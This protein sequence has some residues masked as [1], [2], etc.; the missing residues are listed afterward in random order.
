MKSFLAVCDRSHK[1]LIS[2]ILITGIGCGAT[3][4]VVPPIDNSPGNSNILVQSWSARNKLIAKEITTTSLE[5]SMHSLDWNEDGYP[6]LVL[7]EQGSDQLTLQLNDG[8]GDFF[9]ISIALPESINTIESLRDFNQDGTIDLLT[10]NQD[11]MLGIYY[12][13]GANIFSLPKKNL[14]HAADIVSIVDINKDKR[15][16]IILTT[17][18]GINILKNLPSGNFDSTFVYAEESRD[19][20]IGFG[21]S[22]KLSLE[23]GDLDGDGDSDLII[24]SPI[25]G[26]RHWYK[27]EGDFS[28]SAIVL[29]S[30]SRANFATIRDFDNDGDID[31]LIN[32]LDPSA[33]IL[34]NDGKGNFTNLKLDYKR[35]MG[36]TYNRLFPRYVYS[37]DI[38]ADGDFDLIEMSSHTQGKARVDG[39]NIFENLG[40]VS[41]VLHSIAIPTNMSYVNFTDINADGAMDIVGLNAENDKKTINWLDPSDSRLIADNVNLRLVDATDYTNTNNAEY[42]IYGK[43]ATLFSVNSQTGDLQFK[44]APKLSS[45]NDRNRNNIYELFLRRTADKKS[46]NKKFSISI[47]QDDE[48]DDNDGVSDIHDQFPLDPRESTDSDL[49][50]IGNNEDTDDDNDGALDIIDNAPTDPTSTRPPVWIR[51]P[52][53]YFVVIEGSSTE[54]NLTASDIDNNP[55]EF[56]VVSATP[57]SETN[58][59]G[60]QLYVKAP[61]LA[62]LDANKERPSQIEVIVAAGDGFSN[63]NHVLVVNLLADDG[64]ADDDGVEDKND[65]FPTD[66]SESTD[67]DG[68]GVGDNAD[69]DDDGDGVADYS[70]R[71]P[72][73]KSSFSPPFWESSFEFS[74]LFQHTGDSISDFLVTDIDNDGKDDIVVLSQGKENQLYYYHQTPESEFG[75]SLI[76]GNL[77]HYGRLYTADL[78]NDSKQE[79][80]LGSQAEILVFQNSDGDNFTQVSL[81]DVEAGDRL[82]FGDINSDGKTDIV[83]KRGDKGPIYLLENNGDL[84][85]TQ[86]LIHQAYDQILD[87]ALTDFDGNGT[88][89][90]FG[91]SWIDKPNIVF[92]NDGT[93]NLTQINHRISADFRSTQL[94]DINRDGKMDL[95]DYSGRDPQWFEQLDNGNFTR[96][97][98][99]VLSNPQYPDLYTKFSAKPY[100]L[101]FD[102]D[103]D[104]DFIIGPEQNISKAPIVLL[105]NIGQNYWVAN[106]LFNGETARIQD[107]KNTDRNEMDTP[108]VFF[109]NENI[110]KRS[111]LEYHYKIVEGDTWSSVLVV[112]D[113]DGEQ[114]RFSI[115]DGLDAA[116]FDIDTQTDT[117]TFAL[118]TTVDEPQDGNRDNIYQVRVEVTDGQS[119]STRTFSIEVLPS[120]TQL[121]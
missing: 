88:T 87:F 117:L 89:D 35:E 19:N 64:D 56:S 32:A 90:I 22:T 82:A 108:V 20:S 100:V 37:R 112:N 21:L 1:L 93:G 62:Q 80:I 34:L 16:E 45:P 24:N 26:T 67:T 81:V 23:S 60:D 55:I 76:S 94:G 47:Y 41:F 57:G 73:L 120:Q 53:E 31:V 110:I 5:S 43:D 13:L 103:G 7:H 69:T 33:A 28:F 68:D 104:I 97:R 54:I 6:D 9:S 106:S 102:K 71:S 36:N 115:V 98:I 14:N 95:I 2:F 101:D 18:Q 8:K 99:N 63:T 111:S 66:P 38:D 96:H 46:I 74:T 78:D 113:P 27:N 51:A 29:P 86:R 72:K 105:E 114:S 3:D 70:D 50:G 25:Y 121:K 52:F 10:R 75:I 42:S 85:F 92:S 15:P 107:V 83:T 44:T 116:F 84:N 48:D 91:F 49:D 118:E 65:A 30:E 39:I 4:I 11:A 77:P 79:I 40:D 109:Q 61:L 12:N 59:A 17:D 58:I 119:T